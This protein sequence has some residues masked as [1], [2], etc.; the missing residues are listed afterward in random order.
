MSKYILSIDAGTTGITLLLFNKRGQI[1]IK[2]YS[3][4]TQY[5]PK[6][7]WVEHDPEEIWHA[8][9]DLIIK[10]LKKVDH[11]E[12]KSIG[13]TNQRETTVVWNKI[14][15]KPI[16]NAIVW[17]CS[18]TKD[19]CDDLISKGL[20]ETIKDK[21]GLVIDSYFSASKINWIISNVNEAGSLIEQENLLFGTI[22]A[23]L[24]WKLTSGSS[25]FTDHTNASRTMIYDINNLSWDKYLLDTFSIPKSMLPTIL[26]SA[27]DYGFTTIQS[28]GCK[29]PING[30]A[31]DQQSALF[32]QNGFNKNDI[33]CTYG[34]GC[35]LLVNTGK[36]RIYSD[37]GILTTVA[38]GIDGEPC[39]SLE[40]SVF[41]GGAVIQWLRDGI[42]IIENAS[43]SESIS[44][45][46]DSNEGVYIVPAFAGLGTPYWD[47]DARGLI[48]GITRG[49][50]RSHIVRASIESIAFQVYDIVRTI[51]KDMKIQI[52]KLKVDGGATSN[53][54]L[55]QFQSDIL[56][57]DIERPSNIET[58]ALGA[59]MLAGMRC[60]FWDRDEIIE[61][62]EI[63]QI[64]RPNMNPKTRKMNIEGWKK[65]IQRTRI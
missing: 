5:F 9:K 15:S 31:G 41:I 19:F 20:S 63:N 13:I 17:Q 43:K 47:M 33:K 25:H 10:I 52:K 21:T 50:N 34:T 3:E 30:V 59:A 49:T 2:E 7:G 57:I 60:K 8:T 37:N 27:D 40:G 35:F 29:I 26:N 36:K 53:N 24:I 61:I 38:V 62:R 4:F 45:S 12:I 23:W 64:F 32:G 42:N 22:D 1:V 55:M 65:A 46:L 16:Y 51:N 39:Y 56:D 14:T 6:P 11:K 58:T 18:R 48:S 28:I 44:K 54:F